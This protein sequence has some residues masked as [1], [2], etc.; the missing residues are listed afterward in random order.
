MN[1]WNVLRDEEC[2]LC[3]LHQ[4][5]RA[6][7][8][9]GQG[10]CP[11]D[12]M[13]IG[14]APGEREDAI[15]KPFAGK[16]GAVLNTLLQAHGIRR[17]EVYI[18]N[19]NKCRPVD[20][21]GKNR[22][23]TI[24]ELRACRLYLLE[25]V[26]EL[27]PK[28]ILAMGAHA[29]KGV[30]NDPKASLKAYRGKVFHFPEF[31][32]IPVH[33]SYHP[34]A[35]LYDPYVRNL[36]E[37]DFERVFGSKKTQQRRKVPVR[38]VLVNSVE[39][40]RSLAIDLV[41]CG[42]F[43][44]DFETTG[45]DVFAPDFKLLT[46]AFAT[47]PG[48]ATCLAL[49]HP[50]SKVP[51]KVWKN[52]LRFLLHWSK[53]II[54]HNIKY[55]LKCAKVKGFNWGVGIRDTLQEFHL[56][57]ENYP[58]KSL[59]TL[60]RRWT[61]LGDL[62]SKMNDSGMKS[63]MKSLSLDEVAM[64]NCEDADAT[65][66]V[67]EITEPLI[68]KEN[69]ER[70]AQFQMDA[71][72]CF[73]DVEL[74]GITIDKKLLDRNIK[75]FTQKIDEIQ[76]RF[77]HINLRSTAQLSE[78]LFGTL[79]LPVLET[80]DKGA[81]STGKGVLEHLIRSAKGAK[82]RDQLTDILTYKKL[83][84]FDSNFLSGIEKHIKRDGKIHPSYNLA[85]Y[86]GDEGKE[87]GTV[88][89][90]LSSTNPN[91]QQ[92]PR[93]TEELEKIFGDEA[94]QIREMFISS[95]SRGF[96]TAVDYSQ[97]EL[98]ILA[99][100]SRDQAMME[101]FEKGYDIHTA[102]TERLIPLAPHFYERRGNDFQ[103]KR[104]ATKTVNFGIIYLISDF[105][106][107]ERLEISRDEA[108]DIIRTWFKAYPGAHRWIEKMQRQIVRDQEVRS[109]IGRKRRVPGASFSTAL[110][111]EKIRQ[112]LNAP[113]QGLAADFN[114]LAMIEVRKALRKRRMKSKLCG[115]IHDEALIDTHPKE[116]EVVKHIIQA[117]YLNLPLSRF[118]VRLKVPLE[119]DI[120]QARSWSKK[121]D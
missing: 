58:S 94:I 97:I 60:K 121:E 79:H 50:E 34:A 20:P 72:E 71:I 14:E 80:T 26:E 2:Q 16:A 33:A 68:A 69:M 107:A 24:R 111:R 110:G 73:A 82:Y 39:E 74:A 31:P 15:S 108:A 65:W 42:T 49:D 35:E 81:P 46:V 5:A 30:L 19:V 25:E 83:T 84:H 21:Q 66:R 32:S 112:G 78:Y 10:P 77:N 96:I 29:I 62:E 102:V 117:K 120:R 86:E 11:C 47:E 76:T 101:D 88:T 61:D 57:D 52:V 118:G 18:T 7:C 70:L 41:D 44:L 36:L 105:G 4:G 37:E 99:E 6:V 119:V 53:T 104:K 40:A 87:V 89:G 75:M 22:T 95:F 17:D 48:V 114:V 67:G 106:L 28:L 85:K 27:Q 98:R 90:R 56:L 23:P 12:I 100:Y 109:L 38:Y 54:G 8:L 116:K 51:V 93:D 45:L 3:G 43:S 9:I 92:Q 1:L 113:I 64:Y 13:L 115:N 55:E 59:Y 103:A 63:D 91:L